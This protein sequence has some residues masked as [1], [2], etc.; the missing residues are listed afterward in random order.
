[1]KIRM[2]NDGAGSQGDEPEKH[3]LKGEI[4][5]D[6]DETL[7]NAFISLGAAEEIAE[8]ESIELT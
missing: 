5:T 8:F 7:A 6:V 3:F 4:Y 2:L 1:M